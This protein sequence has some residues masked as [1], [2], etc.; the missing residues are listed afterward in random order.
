M[1]NNGHFG[2]YDLH[3]LQMHIVYRY[4]LTHV[5]FLYELGISQGPDKDTQHSIEGLHQTI[6]HCYTFIISRF[7]CRIYFASHSK[8]KYWEATLA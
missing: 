2:W 5:Q 6:I 4:D 1:N 7:F 3:G 8:L